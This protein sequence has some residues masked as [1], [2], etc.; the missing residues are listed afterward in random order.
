[1]GYDVPMSRADAST[2]ASNKN[3][4]F[5][6]IPVLGYIPAGIPIEA[7]ED[8]VDWEDLSLEQF[9][10]ENQ[11]IGLRVKGDSMEPRYIEGDTLIVRVQSDC[12]SG[13]DAIVYVNGY[14][15]TLKRVVKQQF[16]IMLQPLNPRYEPAFYEYGDEASPIVIAGVVV[17]IRRKVL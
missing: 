16:G 2:P 3:L 6:R 17:E 15:A 13:Q 8:I 5:I 11:Y 10:S 12:E 14:D 7:V 4:N 9:N 1:M